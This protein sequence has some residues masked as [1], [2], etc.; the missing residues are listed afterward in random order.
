MKSSSQAVGVPHPGLLT[1]VTFRNRASRGHGIS[2]DRLSRCPEL[3]K[4]VYCWIVAANA[5]FQC[6]LESLLPLSSQE[7]PLRHFPCNLPTALCYGVA[8]PLLPPLFRSPSP[9]YNQHLHH[10]N[11]FDPNPVCFP[12]STAPGDYILPASSPLRTSV[13]CGWLVHARVL[14]TA[15]RDSHCG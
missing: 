2:A 15:G 5:M 9:S 8:R 6:H 14:E 10:F 11:P 3:T 13:T 1:P 4:P 12:V 7:S